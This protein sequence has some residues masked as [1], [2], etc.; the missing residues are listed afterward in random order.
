MRLLL[1]GAMVMLLFS[2]NNTPTPA[3]GEAG[4][5][6]DFINRFPKLVLPYQ[7][8][9]T[10]L[11]RKETD[12]AA[13]N[14]KM[15]NQFV[16]DSIFSRM[17]AKGDKLR[18]YPLGSTVSKEGFTYLLLKVTGAAK[19]AGYVLCFDKASQFKAGMP[20]VVDDNDAASQ[21]FGSL[22]NNHT[23]HINQQKRATDGTIVYRK[24]SY[25][26]NNAGGFTLVSTETNDENA[27]VNNIIN[28]IDTFARKGKFSGDYVIDKKNFVSVRDGKNET[29]F[30]F[31]IHFDK[32]EEDC[33]GELKGIASIGAKDSALYT[34][35]GDP[36]KLSFRFK[37]NQVQLRELTG[38][39]NHRGLRCFFDGSFTR[40]KEP[41]PEKKK[42][43]PAKAPAKVK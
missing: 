33:S 3:A 9:D 17:F 35:D 40:K 32:G 36:C 29:E 8:T 21:A 15:L 43:A 6:N 27:T 19:K 37:N 41:A 22:D 38:C 34:S 16:P 5:V 42:G 18:A 4:T 30:Q 10:I 11:N 7:L 39:G 25:M 31:F 20:I 26:Y 24:E 13:L 1:M 12:S 23:I 14:S 2:C 28:P